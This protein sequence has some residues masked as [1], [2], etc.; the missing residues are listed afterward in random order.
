MTGV[1]IG[2]S[3]LMDSQFI[4]GHKGPDNIP[5]MAN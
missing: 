5:C 2:E 4:C 3:L 1:M